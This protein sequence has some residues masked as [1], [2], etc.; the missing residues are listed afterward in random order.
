M[1]DEVAAATQI[2]LL[3]EDNDFT[4]IFGLVTSHRLLGA[5]LWHCCQEVAKSVPSDPKQPDSPPVDRK[6]F[7]NA[8]GSDA[9]VSGWG[10]LL[11]AVRFFI[12]QT[13]GEQAA[14]AFDAQ[15]AA[16]TKLR[17]AEN[18]VLATTLKSTQTSQQMD[19]AIDRVG[20]EMQGEMDR[21][22]ETFA[23]NSQES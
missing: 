2:D 14:V 15:L 7:F 5:V 1:I 3:P 13:R 8:L 10:A 6:S 18:R 19:R 4:A 12:L 23:I 16:A 20:E 21:L 17:E 22:L 9:L 11:D